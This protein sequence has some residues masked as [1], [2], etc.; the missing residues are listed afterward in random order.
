MAM[1]EISQS[2]CLLGELH[3]RDLLWSSFKCLL[4]DLNRLLWRREEIEGKPL[5]GKIK[6]RNKGQ[7]QFMYP[8]LFYF[9]VDFFYYYPEYLILGKTAKC[10]CRLPWG[11]DQ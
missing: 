8:A 7:V 11:F 9:L 5:G 10:V 2:S 3:K 4:G 6:Y 1:P